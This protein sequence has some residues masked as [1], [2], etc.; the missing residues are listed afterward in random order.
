MVGIFFFFTSWDPLGAV[1]TALFLSLDSSTPQPQGA[2]CPAELLSLLARRDFMFSST[3]LRWWNVKTPGRQRF[4][5]THV[6]V[7]FL[8]GFG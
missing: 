3:D 1:K 8:G 5:S 2:R 7:F 6:P 4:S